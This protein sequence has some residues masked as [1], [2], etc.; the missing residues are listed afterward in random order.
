[1]KVGA[2][3]RLGFGPPAPRIELGALVAGALLAA[4]D[5]ALLLQSGAS[6]GLVGAAA[7][8]VLLAAGAVA[9][10]ARALLWITAPL[11]H[12]S[13]LRALLGAACSAPLLGVVSVLLFSGTGI[14][15]RWYAPYGPW[16]VTPLACALVWL[17]LLVAIS[18]RRR[19]IPRRAVRLATAPLAL[20]AGAVLI[21]ADHSLYPNQYAYLHWLL[22]LASAMAIAAAVW[23]VSATP[24]IWPRRARQL[25]A[26]L[27][28]CCALSALAAALWGVRGQQAQQLIDSRTHSAGRL[29]RVY[30]GLLDLD[31]DGHSVIFGGRDC[32]N[33]DAAVHPF[34]RDIPRNGR[35]EDCDGR[36]AAPHRTASRAPGGP[37]T[38][39]RYRREVARWEETPKIAALRRRTRRANVLLLTIDA[40][41]AELLAE[42]PRNR[43][44]FPQMMKLLHSSRRFTRAYSSGAGTDIGMSTLLTGALDPFAVGEARLFSTLRRAGY[45]THGV[46]QREVARWLGGELSLRGLSSRQIVINDPHRRDVGSRP[47]ARQVSDAGVA[48]LRSVGTSGEPFLLWLHYFDIHE[49]HQIERRALPQ[50]RGVRRG[51]PFYRALLSHVDGEIGR[52]VRQLE[53][54]GLARRTIVVLASDHG[55]GLAE[56]PRLP[57]NHG[58]V[59]YEPLVHVPLALRLP[60]RPPGVIDAPVSL[61]D[62]YPTLLDLVGLEREP[63]YGLSLL[64]FLYG[65]QLAGPLS[66][67]H[68]PLLLYE[69]KQNGIIVWPWKLLA[70]RGRGLFEL[71]HLE[72]DP[73]ERENVIDAQP[74]IAKRMLHQLRSYPLPEIDRLAALKR[75]RRAR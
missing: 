34:A 54:S 21:W 49:H 22:L 35:D 2:A 15:Q 50:L 23:L 75:R 65:E 74:E 31:G 48:F 70:W 24:E 60:G 25:V 26:G 68:R 32:D 7:A 16:I 40:L 37:L 11:A 38:P 27:I 4:V 43:R 69:Q 42:L 28:G 41:R 30:R 67:L 44:E 17:A 19:L 18:A 20:G 45:R 46:F 66:R 62:V 63:T 39:A 61:A 59:L 13:V 64:P 72:K 57:K 51:M 73:H 58:D 56:R 12:R 9:I 36:D 8:A 71:Y 53:R 5:G 52:V 33:F 1:M 10:A 14:R 3:A 6:I 47:T 55:E 29:I